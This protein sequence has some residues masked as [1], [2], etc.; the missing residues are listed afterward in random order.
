MRSHFLSKA[1]SDTVRNSELSRRSNAIKICPVLSCDLSCRLSCPLYGPLS[2][3][4]VLCRVQSLILSHPLAC[5]MSFQVLSGLYLSSVLSC[6]VL[7][8]YI[9]ILINEMKNIHE[10]QSDLG[11]RGRK[12]PRKSEFIKTRVVG[13]HLYRRTPV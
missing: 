7:H 10:I 3:P 12:Q 5:P 13:V 2:C 6:P 8:I 9:Y 4:L 11:S 1:F